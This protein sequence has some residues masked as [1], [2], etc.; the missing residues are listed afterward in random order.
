MILSGRLNHR[1]TFISSQFS[2]L[3]LCF[4]VK[5]APY[6]HEESKS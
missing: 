1:L 3:S 6:L 2:S 5:L 4:L